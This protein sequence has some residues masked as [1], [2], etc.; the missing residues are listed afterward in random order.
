MLGTNLTLDLLTDAMDSG[1]TVIQ[2]G[3]SFLADN[4]ILLVPVGIG[5]LSAA[6]GWVYNRVR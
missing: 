4:P 1:M 3:F 2:K 5:L 6:A